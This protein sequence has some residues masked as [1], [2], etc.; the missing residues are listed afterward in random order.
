MEKKKYSGYFCSRCKQ[1]PL[2]QII[3]EK[4][5][6][7]IFY[8]CKCH[9]QYESIDSFLKNKFKNDILELNQISKESSFFQNSFEENNSMLKTN[10]DSII[11][12]FNNNKEKMNES[13]KKIKNEINSIYQKK[14]EE[15]NDIYNKHISI[16]NKIIS[17]LEKLLD[18]CLI[19]ND[20]PI[21]IEN[22][23][24]NTIFNTDYKF[25]KLLTEFNS[26]IKSSFQKI[27][28]YFDKELII[29]TNPKSLISQRIEGRYYPSSSNH[30][31]SF[32]QLNDDICAS[33]SEKENSIVLYDL[34][35]E[36]KE[37]VVLKAHNKYIYSM[38]K[39]ESDNII[40][41]GED[42]LIKIWP[43]ITK[44]MI[45]ETKK[46]YDIE[47]KN[48][49][50]FFY[51]YIYKTIQLCLNP[52]FS[53]NYDFKI[54]QKIEK[55]FN[56]KNKC[57]LTT[58][59]DLINIY[60]YSIDNITNNEIKKMKEYE[61]NDISDVFCIELN[62]KE[63]I[64]LCLK[65][66]IDFLYSENFNFINKIDIKPKSNNCLLQLNSQE[67]LIVDSKFHL[68]IY[69][70]NNFKLKIKINTYNDTDYFMNLND[71]TFIFSC[72]EGIKRYLIKKLE[73]LPQIIKFNTNYDDIDYYY[74]Y[75]DIDY[76]YYCEKIVYLYRLKDKR[77]VA[78]FK[79]GNIE[80]INLKF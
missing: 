54:S 5:E 49:V 34:K 79:N 26:S 38:I 22:I 27:K 61:Q 51:N 2:F 71:G 55:M 23:K 66:N 14:I 68:N 16:N 41:I 76:E 35:N 24:N 32:I 8:A 75:Y 50:K 77:I 12:D 73:E 17:V 69:S 45:L 46:K 31:N 72:F 65:N 15:I 11:K 78:C 6:I 10:L 29:Q 80:I 64:A 30:I 7:K 9:K 39:S 70:L 40:S 21:I 57:F 48:K 18:S 28:N 25:D 74:D 53:I 43:K 63:V 58:T 36:I 44:F 37:K 52:I 59:K 42:K 33:C 4:N 20:N 67:I 56:L 19:L 3:H 62:K 13:A 60:N 47:N 1:I